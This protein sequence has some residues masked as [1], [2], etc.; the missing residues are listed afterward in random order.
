M[1]IAACAVAGG[2]ASLLLLA[3]FDPF[4]QATDLDAIAILAGALAA[5]GINRILRA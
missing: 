2:I 3:F 1:E 4:Q 5:V